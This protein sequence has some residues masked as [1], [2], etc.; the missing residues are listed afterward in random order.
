MPILIERGHEVF[1]MVRNLESAKSAFG[2]LPG[3][4]LVQGDLEGIG[5]LAPYISQVE[6]VIHAAALF[7]EYYAKPVPWEKFERLNVDATVELFKMAKALEVKKCVFVSSVGAL[8]DADNRLLDET[9]TTDFYRRSKIL[10][11]KRI[12]AEPS[13]QG[14]PIITIRPSWI[15]GPNDPA[16]TSTGKMAQ[17]LVVKGKTSMVAGNPLSIVDARD[18]A[19]AIALAAEK[20]DEPA[21]F[22]LSGTSISAADALR[23]IA[24][25]IPGSKVD[26]APLWAGLIIGNIFQ[27]KVALF[28]GMNPMPPEGLKFIANG[29]VVNA[30]PS[31]SILG[32]KYRPFEDTARDIAEYWKIRQDGK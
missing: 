23:M 26:T 30:S 21:S 17:E 19:L 6:A 3:L 2:T 28:G 32:L 25:N 22:N 29:P 9:T 16:P 5:K 27:A 20:V 10:G 14:Y 4:T 11:E 1:A 7:T 18:V 15:F 13:L 24:Q 8:A 31:Q 12:A